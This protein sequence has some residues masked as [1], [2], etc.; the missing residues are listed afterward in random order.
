[1][2]DGQRSPLP[3]SKPGTTAA[4]NTL[5]PPG[6]KL[7]DFT[8]IAIERGYCTALQITSALDEHKR[9]NSAEDLTV[10]LVSSGVLTQQQARAC[11]RA[12][13]GA[14]VI[15]GFEILEKVG[16]GGMGAVFRARQ[17]SMDRV[18]ALKILPPKL[19]QDP[20]FKQ[21]FLHEAKLSAKLSHLNI[22]NG[23]DCGEQGG[24]TFFAMEFV[25]GK[26]V[27]Q[28]LKDKPKLD[29]EEAFDIVYQIV[30]ALV[31][32]ESH[33]L[34]HRD[35]KPDNI[36]M[37][38]SGTAKLCDLGLAK[39]TEKAEDANLTQAGQA[40]GTPHYISPEQAR[41]D[42][43]VDT[44]SDI[45]S[46]GGTFYH[47]LTGRTPFDAPTGAAVMALHITD[48][49]KNPCDNDSLIP[50]GY[51]EIISKMMAKSAA[52]RYSSAAA[53]LEEL[54]ATR[55]KDPL[56][57][58]AFKANSS[59]AMP[60]RLARNTTGPQVPGGERRSVG[61]TGRYSPAASS[62]LVM[63]AAG[64]IVVALFGSA[65]YWYSLQG[66]KAP[67]KETAKPSVAIKDPARVDP[68]VPKAPKVP[69]N[70]VEP[71]KPSEVVKTPVKPVETVIKKPEPT[72]PAK[73]EVP[74]A[75]SHLVPPLPAELPIPKVELTADMLYARFLNEAKALTVKGDL[76]K[77]QNDVR[78]LST[79]SD[80]SLAR[81]EISAELSDFQSAISFEQDAVKARAAAGAIV[82][83][84]ED[85][86]KKWETNKG[87][88]IGFD[89]ARGLL[90]EISVKGN[91]LQLY[92]PASSLPIG[93][94]L[95]SAPDQSPLA[96]AR[97]LSARGNFSDAE[98][99]LPK[100]PQKDQ[101]RW[102]RKIAL[103]KSGENELL[104]HAAL[105]NLE[106]IATAKSWKTFAEMAAAFDKAYGDT[107]VA[108]E[109]II[110][111]VEWKADAKQALAIVDN[112]EGSGKFTPVKLPSFNTCKLSALKRDTGNKLL[113]VESA[114]DDGFEKSAI[115]KVELGPI[116]LSTKK[117]FIL[118][119]HQAEAHALQMAIG[120]MCGEKYFESQQVTVKSGPIH[121]HV[122]K[123][124]GPVFKAPLTDPDGGFTQPLDSHDKT[125]MVF[126]IFYTKQP[127]SLELDAIRFR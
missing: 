38:T 45:Y 95:K 37:T 103:A 84:P 123:L 50:T 55:R 47:M 29:P 9:L 19:A 111:I 3:S 32:A 67:L 90:V 71:V 20:I 114:S 117:E 96:H 60:K 120:F 39:Q 102:H 59:C 92:L 82:D 78:D 98:A 127:F 5:T 7:K 100:L 40:V 122:F 107:S 35:I 44:R 24:Y 73:A 119:T 4:I 121:E 17:I 18:V 63:M 57:A 68:V 74:G 88:I 70:K 8:E 91:K 113:H 110:K 42:K 14:T 52:D 22:I 75:V 94:I 125:M 108:T 6:V 97:Y 41:G 81:S 13:R 54:D 115:V 64:G 48:E 15:A 30:E 72:E 106:K 109:N 49:T 80:F 62:P 85:T 11:E 53:L 86:A 89:S 33:T 1:M 36:M 87:K 43:N 69:E 56:S 12:M 23:I 25:D 51:G 34:I 101:A 26:T 21:R 61:N 99:L 58:S 118:Q 31:Y 27:K 126:I 16:Q 28:L 93:D 104:A 10:F 66:A 76:Q 105:A 65:A 83:L 124:E 116:D 77:A 2:A 112:L 79:K 46:L